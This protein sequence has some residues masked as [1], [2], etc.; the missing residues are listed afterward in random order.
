M[1]NAFQNT[2]NIR[3]WQES[4]DRITGST[5]FLQKLILFILSPI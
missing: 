1:S 2:A 4:F 5:G 3:I